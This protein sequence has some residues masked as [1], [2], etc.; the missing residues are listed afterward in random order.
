M[1]TQFVARS[2]ASCQKITTQL[3]P[4]TSHLLHLILSIL[5]GGI[6][7]VVWAIVAFKN[8]WSLPTC[9]LCGTQTNIFGNKVGLLR[10]WMV[11]LV[12]LSFILLFMIIGFIIK[13]I[14]YLP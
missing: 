11:P 13:I 9:T 4:K 12:F 6:W 3:A 5:T 2:C 10:K 7:L 8:S 14:S 1:A